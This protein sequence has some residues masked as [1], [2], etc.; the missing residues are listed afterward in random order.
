VSRVTPQRLAI[1][2][3]WLLTPVVAWAAS[4]L[5]GWLGALIGF[6]LSNGLG[7]GLWLVG[8]SLIGALLGVAG[9]ALVLRNDRWS[10]GESPKD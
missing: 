4:L 10:T 5:G 2:A 9:W 1:I 6:R 7:G 3:G 8:G